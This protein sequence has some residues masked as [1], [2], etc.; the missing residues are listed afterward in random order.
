MKKQMKAKMWCLMKTQTDKPITIVVTDGTDDFDIVGFLTKKSL[1]LA[2][3]DEI[4][5]GEEVRRIEI[6]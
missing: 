1:M 5:D 6:D 3:N 4:G 2:I